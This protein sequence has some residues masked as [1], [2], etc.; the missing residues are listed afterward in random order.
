MARPPKCSVCGYGIIA[1]KNHDVP[2]DAAG[3]LFPRQT[4]KVCGKA[5]RVRCFNGPGLT[6]SNA[7]AGTAPARGDGPCAAGPPRRDQEDDRR[8][9]AS[10]NI[11]RE[12]SN[13]A[14]VVRLT[15]LHN[16]GDAPRYYRRQVADLQVS[17]RKT[18]GHNLGKWQ[19]EPACVHEPATHP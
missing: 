6:G 17:Y 15:E 16:Q 3:R 7:I 9:R 12:R 11:A 14:R 13:P 10:L 2:S 1:A 5:A 8:P 18:R 19:S 4:C